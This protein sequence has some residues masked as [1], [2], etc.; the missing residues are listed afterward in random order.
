ML[1]PLSLVRLSPYLAQGAAA[2]GLQH[3]R[4]DPTEPML[5][6][7]PGVLEQQPSDK[8]NNVR[9]SKTLKDGCAIHGRLTLCGRRKGPD[10]QESIT[11]LERH[12]QGRIK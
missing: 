10:F 6:P 7:Y 9:F 1:C 8:G 12:C 3:Q 11:V 5:L 2:L 4:L